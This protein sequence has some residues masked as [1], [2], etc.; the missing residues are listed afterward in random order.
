MRMANSLSE[1]IM[2]ESELYDSDTTCLAGIHYLDKEFR[3]IFRASDIENELIPDILTIYKYF[4]IPVYGLES[5]TMTIYAS[6]SQN[7]K[8]LDY[9]VERVEGM[10]N[11]SIL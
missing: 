1:Y 7:V 10:I 8:S 9:V 2:S 4:I 6:T 5:L 3:L 11:G